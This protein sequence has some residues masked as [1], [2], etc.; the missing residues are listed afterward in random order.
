MNIKRRENAGTGL[1]WPDPD[2]ILTDFVSNK[3][4]YK[5]NYNN[6][7]SQKGYNYLFIFIIMLTM[8]L[9]SGNELFKLLR[10]FLT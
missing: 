5:S 3:F 7:P 2:K 1:T 9:S 6:Y 10:G 4:L 8:C